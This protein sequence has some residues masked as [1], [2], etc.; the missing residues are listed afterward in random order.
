MD[1]NN[2]CRAVKFATYCTTKASVIHIYSLM[3]IHQ[4]EELKILKM[5]R[6]RSC[7]PTKLRK[8]DS[9]FE[10]IDKS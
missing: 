4:E 7:T 6:D 3:V 10:I 1:S 5:C 8:Q 2:S 9:D